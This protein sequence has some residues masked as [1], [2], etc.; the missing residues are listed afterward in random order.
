M[1]PTATPRASK[2]RWQ[3]AGLA[4]LGTVIT[5]IDRSTISVAL[6]FM[7]HDLHIPPIIEGLVLSW[8]FLAYAIV[9]LPAG[10]L[11]DKFGARLVYGIGGVLW[12]IATLATA[13]VTGIVSL[14]GLRLLLGV[15][16]AAQYPSCIKATQQWFPLRERTAATGLWD[17]GARVG[18]VI[19]LP[20]VAGIIGVAGWRTAFVVVG[21][22]ALI[23][24]I[25]WLIEYRAPSEHRRVNA[26]ERALITEGS[27]EQPTERT[28]PR[29]VELFRHRST[30]ALILGYFCFNYTAYFFITW[31]PSYLVKERGFNLLKLGFFGAIPGLV[32]VFTE[33]SSGFLQDKFI[34]MGRNPIK[35]RKGFIVIGMLISSVIALAVLV[36]S[37]G[38]ALALLTLSYGALLV[39]GPSLGTFP[40]IY[41]PQGSQIGALA[42]VQ[43]SAGNVAGFLGPI[44]TGAIITVTGSFIVPLLLTGGIA[45]LGAFTF[46][47]ILPNRSSNRALDEALTA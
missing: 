39:G 19:T 8:F 1:Q 11:V 10:V 17:L 9:L 31:F 2:I 45:L 40:S 29:W 23:W 7:S 28:K 22:L 27:E 20:L 33:L 44:V 35:V 6:P 21:A 36:P 25:G 3:I 43:N 46:L 13:A 5:N 18:G 37:A 41:A 24:A 30:R 26:A 4:G 34:G 12:G 14:L 32:A 38:V 16:E 15:G 42:G 47:V